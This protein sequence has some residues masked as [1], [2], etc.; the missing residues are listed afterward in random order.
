[1]DRGSLYIEGGE[2]SGNKAKNGAG[3]FAASRNN[4]CV[5]GGVITGN[6]A[7]ENGGGIFVMTGVPSTLAVMP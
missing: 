6:T 2:I 1:M 3:I 7:T 5:Y 4:L